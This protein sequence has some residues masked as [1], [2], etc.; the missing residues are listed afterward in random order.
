MKFNTTKLRYLIH[1]LI[2]FIGCGFLACKESSTTNL[3][4]PNILWITSEDNSPWLGCYGDTRATTPNLDRLA[5]S[6]FVYTHAYANS[7]VCAPTRNTIITG[8]YANSSGNQNMRSHYKKSDQVK[9]F[10][11]FLREAGYYCTNNSK[12]DYNIDPDQT[13]GI[14]N[15]SSKDAHFKNRK[16]GQPFFAVFNCTI[17][18]ESSLHQSIPSDQLRHRP[19]DVVLPPYH[20][21]TEEMRHDWAQYYDKVEDMDKWVGQILLELQESGEAENTIVFYFSDHGGVLARSKRYVYETGSHVPFILHIPE[22]Y[23]HLYPVSEPGSKVNRM[24]SFVDL[25][26]TLLSILG[27]AIPEYMQGQAFLGESKSLDP[28]YA[29]M[30]R[31]RM[32]ERY[33]L[34]RAVRDKKYRYIRNYMPHRI[35]G[36]YLEYLWRAPSVVSWEAAYRDGKC[37]SI[38]GTF[39]NSKPTEELYDTE[40]DPWEIR[41]LANDPAYEETLLRMRKANQNWMSEIKDTGFIPEAELSNRTAGIPAYDYMRT[42]KVDHSLILRAAETSISRTVTPEELRSFLQSDDAAIRYWGATGLLNKGEA[43]KPFLPDIRTAS[44]DTSANVASVAAEL[45]YRLG[46]KQAGRAALLVVLKSD[47]A[48]AR[49]HALNVIDEVDDNSEELKQAVISMVKSQREMSRD[50]YDLRSARQL[51]RKWGVDTKQYGINMDW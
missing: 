9:F 26:P 3:V 50:Y 4:R 8:V 14:W 45:L 1:L 2:F 13:K 31:D 5:S 12:E 47:N 41:N 21:D 34:S 6:G 11:E 18:H 15:E 30:F 48:M 25:A 51:F 19:E 38:Q 28:E 37:D 7:P 29:F 49:N 16:E 46:E 10:P 27:I 33:D 32:D 36:Q 43:A 42:G 44:R 35:Y 40:N 23:T 39:W 22:K 17:T 20:P 24:I